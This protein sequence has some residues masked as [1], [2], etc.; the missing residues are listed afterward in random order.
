MK[1]WNIKNIVH[2]NLNGDT[3]INDYSPITIILI[4]KNAI[5]LSWDN[6]RVDDNNK[7]L[8]F[9]KL[10]LGVKPPAHYYGQLRPEN[11]NTKTA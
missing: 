3:P 11:G 9:F 6:T 1:S 5:H 7:C 10:E 2:N 4:L 8:L